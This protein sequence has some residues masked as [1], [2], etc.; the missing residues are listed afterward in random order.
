MS[1]LP[2]P[3]LLTSVRGGSAGA[4]R[5]T[6]CASS[7]TEPGTAHTS[8]ARDKRRSPLRNGGGSGGP[9]CP[10]GPSI[11]TPS[12]LCPRY[13][14]YQNVCTQ[15]YSYAWWDW[16]R[17]EREI[18]WMALSGINLALAFLGQ[19][20]VWQRVGYPRG[21]GGGRGWVSGKGGS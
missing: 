11:S 14:Y 21:R 16:A 13:R 20:L 8:L 17:W 15:S 18:D 2:P 12:S 9:G 10:P 7:G 1:R 6:V 3:V 19:E 5:A 4:I